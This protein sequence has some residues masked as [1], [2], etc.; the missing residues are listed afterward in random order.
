ME[1][2]L[3]GQLERIGALGPTV[4]VYHNYASDVSGDYRLLVGREIPGA[5][6]IPAELDSVEVSPGRYLVFTFTGEIPGVVIDGWQQVW[7]YFAR[8]R[9][10]Q[11]GYTADLEIYRSDGNGVEIWI[12]VHEA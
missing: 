5:T 3:S 2:D 6:G 9:R 10:E 4:A 11:R 8:P 7:K 1:D 12:A